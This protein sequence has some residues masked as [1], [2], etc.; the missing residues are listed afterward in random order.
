MT[1]EVEGYK[2]K[3]IENHEDGFN[4]EEFKNKYTDYFYEYDY[5][6]G[7]WA[8]G[9]LRLKGFYDKK[10]KA[11]AAEIKAMIDAYDA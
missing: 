5:V 1:I 9:K 3:L 4:E 6:V 7:D 11:K 2:Y 8:Y 10:N